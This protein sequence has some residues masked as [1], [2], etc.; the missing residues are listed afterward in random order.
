[1]DDFRVAAIAPTV[2]SSIPMFVV[3]G[4]GFNNPAIE[5]LPLNVV[6]VV[7][8][9]RGLLQTCRPTHITGLVISVV[10][11]AVDRMFRRRTSSDVSDKCFVGVTPLIAHSDTASAVAMEIAG[12]LV[13]AALFHVRPALILWLMASCSCVTMGQA[14]SLVASFGQFAMQTSATASGVARSSCQQASG[15]QH[16]FCAAV[17]E[18]APHREMIFDRRT[19]DHQQPA[20]A[21]SLKVD[22]LHGAWNFTVECG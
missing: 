4:T 22:D 16:L 1:M 19:L 11:D 3:G 10:V 8:L 15:W 20:E 7:A 21:S 6:Q 13:V 5:A 9:I 12:L 2:P 14:H 18:T 17:T